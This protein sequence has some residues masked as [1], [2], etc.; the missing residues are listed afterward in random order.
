MDALA[1]NPEAAMR[2]LT[3]PQREGQVEDA[4]GQRE[5]VTD[6]FEL[7]Y[8]YGHF[9]DHGAAFGH[10]Y[11]AATDQL[12]AH[13]K[14]VASVYRGSRLTESA[15]NHVLSDSD[16][17][18]PDQSAFVGGLAH[19]LA[20]NHMNDLFD[21]ALRS[22]DHLGGPNGVT[23]YSPDPVPGS[24]IRPGSIGVTPAALASIVDRLGDDPSALETFLHGAAVHQAAIVD[25]NT[26]TP[27]GLHPQWAAQVAAFDSCVLNGTDLHSVA[28]FDAANARHELVAGFFKEAVNGAISMGD[29]VADALVQTGVDAG[30]D[31][32]FP[33]PDIAEVV[34]GNYD[35]KLA[36]QNSLRASVVAGYYKHGLIDTAPPSNI[37]SGGHLVQYGDLED[38]GRP[39]GDFDEW[40]QSQGVEN[41]VGNAMAQAQTTFTAMGVDLYH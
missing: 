39:Q 20:A 37:V 35:A 5:T 2:A 17:G 3:E 14:D 30:I 16:P 10:A 34:S 28:S 6:P 33:G 38:G 41:V 19:D 26:R 24:D 32:V 23:A 31:H 22:Q 18:A 7:L 8:R 11:A 9:G 12:N 13:P 29:P 36:M 15:L 25:E 4:F 1:K 21:S 27:A 40:M